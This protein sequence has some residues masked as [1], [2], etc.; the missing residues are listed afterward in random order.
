MWRI[1]KSNTLA[2]YVYELCER[3]SF[4]THYAYPACLRNHA[5]YW[6]TFVK[7]CIDFV[8][9]LLE[10]QKTSSNLVALDDGQR[11]W[12]WEATKL[13]SPAFLTTRNM[14]QSKRQMVNYEQQ[15]RII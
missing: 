7:D 6:N 10:I 2:F 3:R 15:H 8:L 13:D 12:W 11:R 5:M 1:L 4:F 14:R 9:V